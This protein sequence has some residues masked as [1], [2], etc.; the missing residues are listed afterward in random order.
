MRS[1]K[2][3]KSMK[4][5]YGK[6]LLIGTVM[7]VGNFLLSVLLAF[8]AGKLFDSLESTVDIIRW[9]ETGIYPFPHWLL[10]FIPRLAVWSIKAE[11]AF[12]L[13][14]MILWGC[15]GYLVKR[16]LPTMKPTRWFL[17]PL[18]INLFLLDPIQ[19]LL[20]SSSYYIMAKE[21]RTNNLVFHSDAPKG[22][23]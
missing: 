21:S 15:N 1:K 8:I 10:Y 4:S 19:S 20:G 16:Y 17:V 18:I 12:E 2:I 22:G 3:G 13:L 14:Q 11:I 9:R 23:A 5:K 6:Y 7:I